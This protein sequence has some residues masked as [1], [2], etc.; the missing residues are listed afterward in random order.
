MPALDL[1]LFKSFINFG[2]RGTKNGRAQ[3]MFCEKDL[4]QRRMSGVGS[5]FVT[6]QKKRKS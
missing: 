4:L 2:R 1:L 3:V 6:L 5:G